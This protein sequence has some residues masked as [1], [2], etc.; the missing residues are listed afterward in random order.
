M[1]NEKKQLREAIRAGER[2]L[3]SL[4]AAQGQLDSAKNWGIIDL[5]GGGLLTN[6]VKHSKLENA[7]QELRAARRDLHVFRDELGDVADCADIHLNI[8]DF[9]TFADFFFDGLIADYMV[10]SRIQ[11][12]REQVNQ[13]ITQVEGIVSELRRA[14]HS[15]AE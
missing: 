15:L 1:N 2:A 9:L 11:Q 4:N 6:L 8:G 13:A 14:E 3:F 12:T 5:L 7:E 10:Q